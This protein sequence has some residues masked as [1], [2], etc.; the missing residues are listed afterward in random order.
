MMHACLAFGPRLLL[1]LLLPRLLFP[2]TCLCYTHRSFF[3]AGDLGPRGRL[4]V[5]HPGASLAASCSF[6]ISTRCTHTT[7]VLPRSFIAL[8]IPM[9]SHSE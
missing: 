6:H 3:A 4:Y 7:N 1:L 9:H 5:S 2:H 8:F